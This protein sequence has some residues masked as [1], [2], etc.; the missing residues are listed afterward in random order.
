MS[1]RCRGV[2]LLAACCGVALGVAGAQGV[3]SPPLGHSYG[4]TT[5]QGQLIAITLNPKRNKIAR[6]TYWWSAPCVA[7]PA[8]TPTT[9]TEMDLGGSFPGIPIN[10]LGAWKATESAEGTVASGITAH[11][12]ERVVGRRSGGRM[13]GTLHVTYVETDQAG[14]NV[15]TCTPPPIRFSVAERNIFAG[16]TSQPPYVIVIRI[17]PVLALL[18][19]LQWNW[20]GPCTLGPSA[21]PETQPVINIFPATLLGVTIPKLGHFGGVATAGPTIDAASGITV[22]G[23]DRLVGS[24]TGQLIKGTITSDYTETDTATGGVIRTCSSGPVKFRARD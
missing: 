9:P 24:R 5:S 20:S 21:R 8:A 12:T 6:M 2:L 11:F 17:N 18:D 10:R 1:L 3:V 19:I 15:R 13:V 16:Q 4:G 7:G 22:T 14:Q 23:R